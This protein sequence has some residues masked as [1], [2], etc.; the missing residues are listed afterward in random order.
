MQMSEREQILYKAICEI[1]SV[2]EAPRGASESYLVEYW[3]AMV[4][5]AEV[6]KTKFDTMPPDTTK[7]D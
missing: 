1:A 3:D 6:A 7:T 2:G 5:S 4:R